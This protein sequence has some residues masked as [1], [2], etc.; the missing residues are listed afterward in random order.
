V[1]DRDWL[2]TQFE[3]N[4]EHLRSVAYGMLGSLSE[5]DDAVQEAWLRLDRSD[6]D[7]IVDLQAWLTTVVGRICLDMLRARRTRREN[8]VGSWLPEPV[9]ALDGTDGPEQ[10]AVLSEA[11]GLAMLVVLDQ[12]SPPERLAFVLHD[13]FGVSFDEIGRIA[14]RSTEAAR[15]LASRAR[16]RV[17]EAPAPDADL[18]LQRRVVDAF[19]AAA[20]AGDMAALLEVLDPDVVFRT[21]AGRRPVDA[22]T[23]QGATAVLQRVLTT[24]PRFAHLGRPALVNGQA[25]VVV[26][27]GKTVA[28]LGC[29]VVDG[30]IKELNLIVDPDK[31]SHIRLTDVE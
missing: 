7:V 21:D 9:V 28:V 16:R 2:A 26:G 8:Y 5:A 13:V 27:R 10:E 31:I 4:R 25:G 30:R 19:L 1:S 20:R 29:T 22:A 12:L 6:P 3:G 24:A 23:V 15:Q 14:G 11:V 18:A 17:R